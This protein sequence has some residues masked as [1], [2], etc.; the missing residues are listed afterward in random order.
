MPRPKQ[1]FVKEQKKF[2]LYP[3]DMI[4]LKDISK[5]YNIS[6]QQIIE[7]GMKMFIDGL[8][9]GDIDLKKEA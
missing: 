4:K 2:K 9:N 8:E 1:Q 3:C 5:K 6:E 7:K